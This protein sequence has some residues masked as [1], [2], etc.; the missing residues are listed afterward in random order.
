MHAFLSDWVVGIVERLL[1]GLL[2][3]LLGHFEGASLGLYLLTKVHNLLL[4]FGRLLLYILIL[5]SLAIVT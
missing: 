5:F 4:R 2:E 1:E 3:G